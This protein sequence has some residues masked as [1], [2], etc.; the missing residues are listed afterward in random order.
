[1]SPCQPISAVHITQAQADA[2]FL[3]EQLEPVLEAL[4]I[5]RPAQALMQQNL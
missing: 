5:A 4:A 2:V 1:M 3:G